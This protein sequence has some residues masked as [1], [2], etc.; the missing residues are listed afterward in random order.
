MI[1]CGMTWRPAA[2]AYFRQ[3][4]IKKVDAVLLTHGHND[5]TFEL[6]TFWISIQSTCLPLQYF[7]Y[8]RSPSTSRSDASASPWNQGP[9]L[10]RPL[11]CFYHES[12]C[13]AVSVSS[14]LVRQTRLGA[15]IELHSWDIALA[16]LLTQAKL[17]EV[18][19]FH[20]AVPYL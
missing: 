10:G 8:W 16:T 18:A 9:S 1:D 14:L 20:F 19:F 6:P 17:P 12:H 15:Y 4:G 5:G 7:S 13:S 2:D 3:N 11:R